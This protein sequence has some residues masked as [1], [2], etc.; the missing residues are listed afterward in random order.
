MKTQFL[1]FF[2]AMLLPLMAASQTQ[3]ETNE[4]IVQLQPGV[5]VQNIVRQLEDKWPSAKFKHKKELSKRFNYQLLEL[6]C[7]AAHGFDLDLLRNTSGVVNASWNQAIEFRRDPVTPND[8]LFPSQWNMQRVGLP[9][10]WP[11]A[12]GGLTPGGK[13]IVVAIIDNGFDLL[14]PDLQPNYWKNS[15]EAIDGIDNDG[16][17]FVDDVYGWNF[18]NDSPVLT[19]TDDHATRVAGIIGASGNN[20][21]GVSGVNW[22]VKIMPIQFV[23]TAE[24]IPAFEYVL[25]MREL[26][27]ATNGAKGAYIV[28]TNGSFGLIQSVDCSV[29]PYWSGY[30]DLLGNIG[31]L[32][33]AAT[34]NSDLDIDEYG[35]MPT[36]C[37]SE[38]LITVTNTDINDQKVLSAGY[39]K[40]TI[41]LAAPGQDVPSTDI[42]GVYTASF[43]GTSAACPLVTGTIALLYSLPCSDLEKLTETDPVAAARLV[44]NALM[45]SVEELP[46]LKD[47][48]VTGGLLNV[49]KTMRHLHSYCIARPK[50][51]EE[52]NFEEIYLGGR[53]FLRISPNPT[54]DM[55]NVEYSIQ[56]FKEIKFRVFNMLGQEVRYV[57]TQ[58]AEPFEPQSFQIDV[59]SWA[60][61]TYFINIYD[62]GKGISRKFVKL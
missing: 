23:N 4:I 54:S 2:F 17:G 10:V 41:D 1:Y 16:N 21:Q 20:E 9:S 38:F 14:H 42:G 37:S 46:G 47:I 15:A 62:L 39:G 49:Y 45:V 58:Q 18:H 52:G 30:Y 28:A 59:S 48:S 11:Y 50:E 36:S 55:L 35:D 6:D 33:V 22:Q 27:N 34:T 26:Y 32:S 56:D 5:L 60:A 31:V 3:C 53:D 51:R 40:T 7:E 13:E 61:G 24:I 8:P 57:E 29:Q 43:R 44:K 12:T 25:T 19:Q